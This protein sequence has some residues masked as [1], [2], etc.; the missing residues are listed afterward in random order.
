[1]TEFNNKFSEL[2][3]RISVHLFDFKANGW[4]DKKSRLG[5]NQCLGNI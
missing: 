3:N 2:L 1:M 4:S 5:G